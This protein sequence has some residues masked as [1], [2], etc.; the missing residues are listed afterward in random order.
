MKKRIILSLLIFVLLILTFGCGKKV[1]TDIK[2][3]EPKKE[4]TKLEEGE[5]SLRL[6]D[7]INVG[8]DLTISLYDVNDSRCPINVECYWPGE[9]AYSIS[10]NGEYNKISTVT[11]PK[12][13]Y[14]NYT[15]KIV[16]SKCDAITLVFEVEKTK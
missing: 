3:D 10:I 5:Y 16:P 6:N 12:I 7:T 2:K 15:L 9:L 13:T 8:K 11:S 4:E 1:E 14:K